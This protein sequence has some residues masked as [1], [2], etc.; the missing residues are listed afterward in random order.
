MYWLMYKQIMT[1]KSSKLYMKLT[2]VDNNH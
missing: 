1:T 2:E